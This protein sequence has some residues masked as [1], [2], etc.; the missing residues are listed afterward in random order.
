[1]GVSNAD[2]LFSS[3]SDEEADICSSPDCVAGLGANENLAQE[4]HRPRRQL[5]TDW[6]DRRRQAG[7][8][9]E[10]RDLAGPGGAAAAG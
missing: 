4:H 3:E 9:D 1:M 8:F 7:L 5:C 2:P 10:M 6:P